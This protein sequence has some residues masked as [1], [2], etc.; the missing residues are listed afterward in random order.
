MFGF[1]RWRSTEHDNIAMVIR[2]EQLE[3]VLG[4]SIGLN[5]DSLQLT[6]IGV[7]ASNNYRWLSVTDD[8]HVVEKKIP[9]SGIPRAT[10]KNL[11]R[12]IY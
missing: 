4:Y 12:C 5:P 11:F 6:R 7:G 2:A 10:G 3:D 1:Q 8:G 9:S